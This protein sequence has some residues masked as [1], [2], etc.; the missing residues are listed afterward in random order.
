MRYKIFFIVKSKEQYQ[1][2]NSV[3]K[4]T[5]YVINSIYQGEKTIVYYCQSPTTKA[6]EEYPYEKLDNVL[7][8]NYKEVKCLNRFL[9]II[10]ENL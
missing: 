7:G 9:K 5:R 3:K 2:I 6:L 4:I 1:K 8:A 10:K